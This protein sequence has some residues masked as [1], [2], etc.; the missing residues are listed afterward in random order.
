[1]DSS[2]NRKMKFKKHSI[3]TLLFCLCFFVFQVKAQTNT[4]YLVGYGK[5]DITYIEDGLGLFGFGNYEQRIDAKDG[6]T[7]KIYSRTVAIKDPSTSKQVIYL[8]A[9][10]GAIFHSL[11]AGLIAKIKENLYP[12]FDEASLMMT[13]S[14]THCAA[15]GMSHH[16]FYM[17]S[18]PGYNPALVGFTVNGMYE[19]VVQAIESQT[20]STIEIKE[21]RFEP[22]I[23]VAFNRALKAHNKNKDIQRKYK[24]TENHLAINRNMPLMSFVDEAGNARGFINWFGVHPIEVGAD[25]DFIDGASKGYA[26]L[27]AEDEMGANDVAIFAQSSAGDVMTA[28][29][30]NA[31]SFETE[32]RIVL[33]DST[34]DHKLTSLKH[35]RWNGQI[36]ADKA[37]SI[38]NHTENFKVHGEIDCEFIYVDMSEVEVDVM[39]SNGHKEAHTSSPILG[40]PF[41][42]GSFY[43]KDGNANRRLLNSFAITSKIAYRLRSPFVDADFRTYRNDLFKSQAPKKFVI[44]GEEKS[45]FGVKFENYHKKKFAK[46]FLNQTGKVDLNGQEVVRQIQLKAMEEHTIL[47]TILPIQIIRIGNIAIAGLPTEI[48]TV[49]HNRLQATLREALKSG[50]IDEVFISSYANEYAG[51]TTTYEEYSAQRYEGGH[52]LYGKHQLG[53]FQTEFKKLATELLKPKAQRQLNRDIRPPVFSEGE[54]NERSYLIPLEK[55]KKKSRRK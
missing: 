3:Y 53:A 51:Y 11:R 40:A 23:P 33:K 46:F 43:W 49:A 37:L 18:A 22:Y 28:D 42:S 19:S 7:S 16:A 48:T 25:H 27:Y 41:L 13:A 15:S 45:M 21:G 52:T 55:S 50:G 38:R 54:L 10:L 8:H 34:Y 36:Q 14:H 39:H 1:L 4:Q 44:N 29:W 24:R 31:K 20:P 5:A 17:T 9:D 26:A 12:D 30:H 2:K 32:M 47:P 35:A 6:F